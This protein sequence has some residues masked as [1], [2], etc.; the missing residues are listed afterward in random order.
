MECVGRLGQDLVESIWE[1]GI[2]NLLVGYGRRCI[3]DVVSLG[4]VQIGEFGWSL[5]VYFVINLWVVGV[6][7]LRENLVGNV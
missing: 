7:S 2:N 3:V 6:V 5:E 4:Y 1:E